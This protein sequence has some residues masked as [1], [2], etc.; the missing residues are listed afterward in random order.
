MTAKTEDGQQPDVRLTMVLTLRNGVQIRAAVKDANVRKNTVTDKLNGVDWTLND[1]PYGNSIG[2]ID[3]GE[4][5]AVHFE[6]E[7]AT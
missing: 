5:V 4:V 2:W 6:R 3:V 1:D 7:P